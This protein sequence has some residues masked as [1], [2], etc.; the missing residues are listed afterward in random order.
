M[1]TENVFGT[2]LTRAIDN[3]ADSSFLIECDDGSVWP[4]DAAA[5]FPYAPFHEESHNAI[6]AAA[7]KAQNLFVPCLDVGAGTGR[8]SIIAAANGAKIM[9]VEPDS[10]AAK[11]MSSF[12]PNATMLCEPIEK[13]IDQAF[14]G[15]S[16]GAILMMGFNFGLFGQC[17]SQT[18]AISAIRRSCRPGAAF[19]AE[20]RDRSVNKAYA[21]YWRGKTDPFQSIRIGTAQGTMSEWMK[22]WLPTKQ[23]AISAMTNGGWLNVRTID[24]DDGGGFLIK[25]V[26]P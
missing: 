22:W 10:V 3:P 15:H 14:F 5:Y 18:A 25:A 6:T 7:N 26:A 2:I 11:L 19:V 24:L 9:A 12:V 13:C 1:T 17:K 8:A 16:F 21:E 20:A 23:E 4:A